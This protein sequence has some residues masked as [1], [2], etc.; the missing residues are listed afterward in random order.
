MTKRE[1]DV[2]DQSQDG[3]DDPKKLRD[4]VL[5]RS[6]AAEIREGFGRKW[7]TQYGERTTS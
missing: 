3:E 6:K 2:E 4:D 5:D 7:V 1:S